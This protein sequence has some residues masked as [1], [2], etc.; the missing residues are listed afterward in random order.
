[1]IVSVKAMVNSVWGAYGE[2]CA[3]Q[4]E[5]VLGTTAV[6][7]S[8]CGRT[9]NAWEETITANV[10]TNAVIYEWSFAST[11]GII[12]TTTIGN[13]LTITE[14]LGLQ[15]NSEYAVTVRAQLGELGFTEW[16]TICSI[17][18]SI[19]AVGMNEIDHE[20]V[21]IYPNPSDGESFTMLFNEDS[22]ASGIELINVFNNQGQL[23]EAL[24]PA[25]QNE[26]KGRINYRFKSK[27]SAGI[28]FIQYQRGGNKYEEK[29]IVR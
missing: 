17:S 25:L 8:D 16:G 3:L 10:V 27:L 2:P 15:N 12:T 21:I 4:T 14:Q 5:Q 9:L 23:I 11:D 29:L 28:Y 13:T 24:T 7:E 20:S 19:N 26:N 22:N 6:S 18:I 1:M